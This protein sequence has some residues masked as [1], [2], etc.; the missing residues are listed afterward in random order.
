MAVEINL[1]GETLLEFGSTLS[2][3]NIVLTLSQKAKV[4]TQG[5]LKKQAAER[6]FLHC[7]S[8]RRAHGGSCPLSPLI[9]GVWQLVFVFYTSRCF[10]QPEGWR[11]G[12]LPKL[13]FWKD[14]PR[15]SGWYSRQSAPV[16]L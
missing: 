1:V 11:K 13:A 3:K 16:T 8:G 4:I 9:W 6:A 15:C 5:S 12:V 2:Y 10:Q 14:S 7:V